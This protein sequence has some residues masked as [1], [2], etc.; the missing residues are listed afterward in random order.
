MAKRDLSKVAVGITI[1]IAEYKFDL[2][3]VRCKECTTDA[4]ISVC[5]VPYTD[6]HSKSYGHNHKQTFRPLD[7]LLCNDGK[8]LSDEWFS[9]ARFRGMKPLVWNFKQ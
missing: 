6:K 2:L 3:V 1:R 5:V 7:V 8:V 9:I 4:Y